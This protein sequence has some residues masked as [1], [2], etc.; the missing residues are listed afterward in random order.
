[1]PGRGRSPC[2]GA[3]TVWDAGRLDFMDFPAPNPRKSWTVPPASTRESSSVPSLVLEGSCYC[4]PTQMNLL[5]SHQFST[6][7][8]TW[9]I[10]K[11]KLCSHRPDPGHQKTQGKCFQGPTGV[12][13]EPWECDHWLLLFTFVVQL[14]LYY[15]SILETRGEGRWG[16]RDQMHDPQPPAQLQDALNL[17]PPPRSVV[18][19]FLPA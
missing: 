19:P 10:M 2:T 9:A 5:E 12:T 15:V 13:W 1:M 4:L 11:S 3:N 8:N 7:Q 17:G 14:I 18:C 6:S 16:K